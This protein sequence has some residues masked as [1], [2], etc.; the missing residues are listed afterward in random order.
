MSARH[1]MT[2]G[3]ALMLGA[4]SSVICYAQ[5][6]PP[7]REITS[8]GFGRP[9]SDSSNVSN[10][11]VTAGRPATPRPGTR[12]YTLVT[13][14]PKV[15]LRP[16]PRKRPPGAAGTEPLI[17]E[18][19][20]VTL[21]RLRPRRATDAGPKM[22]V[23][24]AD[25]RREWWSPERVG[26]N[27]QFRAGDRVRLTIESKR[28]GYLYV[29]NSEMYDNEALGKPYL[30]FPEPANKD[31]EGRLMS[32]QVNRVGP[33]FLVDIP[34]QLDDLPYFKIEPKRADYVGELI[35]IVISPTPLEGLKI[36][37]PEQEIGN[38]DFLARWEGT[39]ISLYIRDGGEGEAFTTSEQQAACGARARQ[40]VRQKP[41]TQN[42]D[43]S[44]CA[45]KTRQL[46]REEPLPQSI[47]SVSVVKDRPF[48][49]P[50]RISVT[51]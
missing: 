49:I 29:V 8:D 42:A 38:I 23:Q 27:T 50:V 3:L 2:V 34:S 19:V 51:R 26:A 31:G 12:K 48:I 39:D 18:E 37:G 41:S 43:P 13:D 40:L 21:W 46:T 36:T 17:V 44:P 32:D 24:V 14:K 35:L 25:G 4:C 28:R 10:S 15:P 20:G 6:R 7:S 11:P 5:E 16:N 1:V 30:L 9:P 47:Y 22:P 33:G 45:A